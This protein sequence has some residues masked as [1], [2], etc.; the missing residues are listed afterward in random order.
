M[1]EAATNFLESFTVEERQ[2]LLYQVDSEERLNWHYVPRERRGISFKEMNG[3]QE[4]LAHVLISSGL[5]RNGYAK[6][7]NIMSLETILKQIE[8]SNS[9][10]VRDPNL[11]YITLF[12]IPSTESPWGWRL[13]GHHVSLNFLV[14]GGK[15]VA[16][17]PN[18]FGA[19]PAQVP[20]EYPLAAFRTLAAE[21]DLARDL[22][23]ALKDFQRKN[24]VIDAVAPPDI[25]TL[26]DERVRLDA[27]KGLPASEMTE[28]QQRNLSNLVFEYLHRMPEDVAHAQMSQ[29]EKEGKRY[30]HFAWA[31]SEERGKPHYYRVHG[32]TFLIEYDNTQN[33]ANHIHS[34]WRDLRNDWGEDFLKD[35][36]KKSHKTRG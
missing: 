4:K 13:E 8:G 15:Y 17:T 24:A 23:A 31:G 32:P 19:N 35:H 16:S 29:I 28:I 20:P 1:A 5:S 3:S 27:P 7:M 14:V 11:Y 12:G 18:F 33:N 10:F 26:A 22:L 9:R 34:V 30:I 25:I 36:Y 6:A 21:E 2:R